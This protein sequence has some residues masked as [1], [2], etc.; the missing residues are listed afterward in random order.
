M[1]EASGAR[2]AWRVHPAAER[3]RMGLLVAV[4]I[5]V[6]SVLAGIWMKQFFWT[7]FSLIVLFLSLEAFFLPSRFELGEEEIAVRKP[8][9]R[10]TRPW[11]HFRR[12][13]FDEAGVT[14]SPFAQRRW[15]EP[16]RAIRLNY[17]ATAAREAVRDFIL[18]H[19]DREKVGVEGL[20][21]GPG[22]KIVAQDEELT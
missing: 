4:L 15:I 1:P 3:P 22:E 17:G 11:S 21:E 16:Y 20:A 9:S 12:V 13:I 7:V 8:F 6:L 10:L 14:L 19:I 2:I 18:A 5:V